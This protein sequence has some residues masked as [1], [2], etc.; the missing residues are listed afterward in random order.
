MVDQGIARKLPNPDVGQWLELR[1]SALRIST[2]TTTPD[3][4]TVDWVPRE[5]QTSGEIPE[6]PPAVRHDI[7]TDQA[8]IRGDQVR[9]TTS[10]QFDTGEAGP[11]GH[12]PILRPHLTRV[13]SLDDLHRL[14]S[15]QGGLR[16]N[17]NRSNKKPTDPNPAGY[18]HALSSQSA[19]VYGSDAWLNLW[20]PMVDIPSSP[21][22]DHSISQL[23]LQNYQKPQLQSLE[24][25]LTVD[26]DLN[27]G[28]ANYLFTYYTTNGYSRDGNNLGGYN[29]LESGW[30]QY[31][32]SI[33]PG[34]RINGSSAQGDSPQLEIGIKYQ[35]WQGNWW[36]GF[37]NNES[38]PWIWLGYYPGRLFAGGIANLAEWVGWGGEVYSGL[39]NPCATT[40]QMGSGRHAADGWTHAC[41]QRL[42]HNQTNPDGALVNYDGVASVDVAA[43]NCPANEY[44][45]ETFM[46][47]STNW[48]SYQFFGGP[49]A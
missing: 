48:G 12:V 27:G 49:A 46:N 22:D 47:S 45:I 3:G 16:V 24:G 35:L 6:P 20:D 28:G 32:P 10:V 2:T 4:Q 38:G 19:T 41:Y 5:S 36:F 18:F 30:V 1:Q 29:R 17:V 43:S 7:Q 23:W 8:Q 42:I 40:D 25:G 26:H 44:T 14:Q 39:A 33:Y 13:E 15:K 9:P 21:G 34:I 11:A 37:N 31:H